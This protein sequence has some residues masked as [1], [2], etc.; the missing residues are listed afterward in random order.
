MWQLITICATRRFLFRGCCAK[1]RSAENWES[2]FTCPPPSGSRY[3]PTC[4]SK[5]LQAAVCWA[6]GE[7]DF[8][9]GIFSHLDWVSN[10]GYQYLHFHY[11]PA[12]MLAVTLFLRHHAGAVAARFAGHPVGGQPAQG[13]CGPVQTAEHEN[14]YF[15]RLPLATPSGLWES[16]GSVC[17]SRCQRRFLER[18]VHFDQRSVL[19][20][21][22]ARVVVAGG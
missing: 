18:G 21:G 4:H 13:Q 11:N 15:P 14:T 10:T 7:T 8:P 3:S 9:Y 1:S 19:D 17:F 2:A 6:R 22:L 12:H 20:A 16:T 5:I